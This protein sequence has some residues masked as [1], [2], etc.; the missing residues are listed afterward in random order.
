MIEVRVL[1]DCGEILTESGPV[2]LQKNTYHYLRRTDIEHLIRQNF[3]E[4]VDS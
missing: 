4:H 1:K 3:V 2:V